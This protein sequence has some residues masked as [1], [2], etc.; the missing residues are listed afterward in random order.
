MNFNANKQSMEAR[1]MRM[2][3]NVLVVMYSRCGKMAEAT[4]L[5]HD[6]EVKDNVSWNSVLSR[7]AQN[8]LY[9]ET[10]KMFREMQN[11]HNEPDQCS[12]LSSGRLGL[13][14]TVLLFRIC[15]VLHFRIFG[16][17][18]TFVHQS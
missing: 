9:D 2:A 15:L 11:A 13:M 18:W 5:F 14:L 8:G 17:T 4:R 1:D 3:A 6:I 12:V 7:L 10:V 16:K